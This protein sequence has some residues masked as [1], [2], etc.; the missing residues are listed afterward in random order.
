MAKT[1]PNSRFVGYDVLN[2][3]IQAAKEEAEQIVE[4]GLKNI[5]FGTRDV[6]WLNESEKYDLI[7][8]FDTIHDQA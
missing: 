1:Y 7:T 3:A 2:E 4:G 5:L 6:A 8:A